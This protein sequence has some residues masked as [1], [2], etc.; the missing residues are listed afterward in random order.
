MVD[1]ESGAR[2]AEEFA[3][4]LR[5]QAEAIVAADTANEPGGMSRR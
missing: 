3:A 1:V 4:A 2:R 5:A